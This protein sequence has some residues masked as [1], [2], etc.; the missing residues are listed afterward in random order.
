MANP[1]G[2]DLVKKNFKTLKDADLALRLA[3]IGQNFFA[4][5]WKKQ[6]WDDGVIIPWPEVQRRMTPTKAYKYAKMAARTRA[7]NV[8]TGR[9]RRAV[10]DSVREISFNRI[11]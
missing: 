10:Q 7:I 2:L 5:S 3:N 6:G 4:A 11:R 8:K 1:F 9:L